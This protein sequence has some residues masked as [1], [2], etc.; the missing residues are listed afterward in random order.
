[1][2]ILAKVFTWCKVTNSSELNSTQFQTDQNKILNY[3]ISIFI[4]RS[5]LIH[6]SAGYPWFT[7]HTQGAATND[8]LKWQCHVPVWQFFSFTCAPD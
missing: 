1:M 6:P 5:I 2:A 4:K 3:S 8:V 7:V